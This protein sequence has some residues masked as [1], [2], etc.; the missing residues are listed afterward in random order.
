[1]VGTIGELGEAANVLKK[2]RRGDFT[3]DKARP[4]LTQE[5]ADV[6]VYLDILAAKAGIDLGEAVIK[7]FNNKSKLVKSKV[8][9]KAA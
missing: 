9:L 8:R 3:L 6:V 5:F 4:K 1:M 2:V 7:T